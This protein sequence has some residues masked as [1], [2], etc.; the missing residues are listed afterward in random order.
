MAGSNQGSGRNKRG[1]SMKRIGWAGVSFFLKLHAEKLEKEETRGWY[2]D[3]NEEK[4]GTGKDGLQVSVKTSR[5]LSY[6]GT[7]FNCIMFMVANSVILTV[8][9]L[10][11]HHR[12]SDR[13]EMR[14][15]IKTLFLRWLP[16]LLRMKRPGK[17][18]KK[19]ILGSNRRKSMELQEKSSKSLLANVLNID[20]DIR[21][22][23]S[24]G[25]PP[26][27]YIRSAFGT[28][29]STGRPATV[30]DTSA[31]LPLSGVQEELHKIL[32]ELRFITERMRKADESDQ[33]ISDWKFAAM[34]VD[35]FSILFPNN[36]LL[37]HLHVVHGSGHD[38]DTVS[39][40]AHNCPINRLPRSSHRKNAQ[41]MPKFIDENPNIL[42]DD[43]TNVRER[44]ERHGSCTPHIVQ[45][46]YGREK[47]KRL[48][49]RFSENGT[50][51]QYSH[52]S[53]YRTKETDRSSLKIV[54]TSSIFPIAKLY[55]MRE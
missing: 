7:Y 1:P 3:R 13:Y 8:L 27:S 36:A 39:C 38:S 33:V 9:V 15:W 44:I 25:N 52:W 14:K 55:G 19:N 43:A 42:A 37:V 46:I 48:G 50:M 35:R 18:L 22:K 2:R 11:F 28:P 41:K 34:V 24:A 4:L 20:D 10:N 12:T 32:K 45:R 40:A 30:E 51:Q 54:E 16:C 21:H 17:D 6:E 23:N 49:E 29:I 47:E 53:S 5:C 31:S 26:S